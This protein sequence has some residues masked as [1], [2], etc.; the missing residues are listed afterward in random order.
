VPGLSRSAPPA[1]DPAAFATRVALIAGRTWN[2]AAPLALAVSG[3]PD[4]LALLA[5][6]HGAFGSRCRVLTVDHGLRPEAAAEADAVGAIARALGLSH[7]VLRPE[8][9][10]GPGNVQARARAARYRAMAGWCSD[11]GIRFLLT[12]HHADDQAET[13]LLRL[14]RGAGLDGLSGIRPARLIAPGLW[15]LRPL[16]AERR[17]TLGAIARATGWPVVDDP[18]NRDPRYDRTAARALLAET[19][20]LDAARL[21]MSARNLAHASAALDWAAGMVWRSRVRPG[22][23]GLT[24]D[25]EALPRP[26]A[27]HCLARAVGEMSGRAADGPSIDR[28][29]DRLLAGR[30]AHLAD[31]MIAPA[32]PVWTVTPAPPRRSAG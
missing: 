16:L 20:W 25:V 4:S 14:A 3:G 12:A 5:L 31:L 10:P 13:L 2:D 30:P 27:R 8:V 11:H 23:H 29:V 1:L 22:E 21:A 9:A 28:A 32:G 6:A 17:A 19:P 24:I 15:L 26:F 7:A 18:S